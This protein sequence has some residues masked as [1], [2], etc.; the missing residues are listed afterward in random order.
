MNFRRID[1]NTVQCRM[2]EEEMEEY[3]FKIED[4]FTDQDKTRE[5]LEQL[6]EQRKKSAM[7]LKAALCPCN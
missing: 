7:K 1:K 4:F 5:F 2:S 3:G 6:V